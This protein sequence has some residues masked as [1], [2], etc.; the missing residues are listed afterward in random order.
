MLSRADERDHEFC[1]YVSTLTLWGYRQ[2]SKNV[3]L[4]DNY[5]RSVS[6]SIYF[7]PCSMFKVYS[8]VD[9]GRVW[10]EHIHWQRNW[11]LNERIIGELRIGDSLTH[12]VV[13]ILIV[14]IGMRLH[15][16]L[17][18]ESI[19]RNG[20][21]RLRRKRKGICRWRWLSIIRIQLEVMTPQWLLC[22]TAIATPVSEQSHWNSLVRQLNCE[23]F[24]RNNK[25]ADNPQKR[26]NDCAALHTCNCVNRNEVKRYTSNS[27]LKSQRMQY[28]WTA[29]RR[30]CFA[31]FFVKRNYLDI[32]RWRTVVPA[33]RRA[34]ERQWWRQ[35]N[36]SNPKSKHFQL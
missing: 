19:N 29:H 14:C 9:T 4:F 11:V 2:S 22:W 12:S 23:D 17:L 20:E 1:R 35:P 13:C 28:A 34:I 16:H 3:V 21:L 7:S 24:T 33:G 26:R 32:H 8:L 6:Q 25:F 27:G 30:I 10:R 15:R 31:D 36:D 18:H 5:M